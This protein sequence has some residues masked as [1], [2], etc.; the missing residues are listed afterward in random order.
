MRL[1]GM[2][3]QLIVLGDPEPDD[4]VILKFLCI[5]CPRFKQLVISIETLL[6]VST[7]SLEEVT[8]QLRSA[9]EDGVVPRRGQA[10][11][12]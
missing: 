4:K 9:E 5:A 8:D 7:L 10:L 6:D 1:T 11:L 3:N 12:N 2:V